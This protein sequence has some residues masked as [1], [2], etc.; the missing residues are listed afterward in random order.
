M[1]ILTIFQICYKHLY[2][3]PQPKASKCNKHFNTSLLSPMINALS[4]AGVAMKINTRVKLFADYILMRHHNL[5][6]TGSY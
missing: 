6:Y 5:V 2:N 1:E 3:A 4:M